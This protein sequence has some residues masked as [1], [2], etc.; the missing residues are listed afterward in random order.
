MSE[1]LEIQIFTPPVADECE[2]LENFLITLTETISKI[3]EDSVSHGCLG[4]EFGYG[5][6]FENDVFVMRPFYWGDCDCGADER[7]EKWHSENPHADNCFQ[8]ELHRRLDAYDASSGYTSIEAAMD[9]P[10]TMAEYREETPF[11]VAICSERTPQGKLAHEAWCVAHTI[12]EKARGEITATLYD[13]YNLPRS[14]YQWHCTCGV[15]EK[16]KTYF[17]TE[18]HYPTC[19]LELPNFRHKPSGFEVRWYKWIGRDM[20]IAAPGGI[21][22]NSIFN[23]CLASLRPEGIS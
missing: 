12:R 1:D 15:D 14:R 23:E 13:E 19:A 8:T 5:A 17:S 16:A 4:G 22:Q 21:D 20:E 10:G 7:S 11:G 9:A 18:G 3:D 2:P 6:R